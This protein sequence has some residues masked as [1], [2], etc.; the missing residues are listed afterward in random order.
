MNGVPNVINIIA[1]SSF[2]PSRSDGSLVERDSACLAVV[3]AN[4]TSP[5][6]M[7]QLITYAAAILIVLFIPGLTATGWVLFQKII[8][9]SKGASPL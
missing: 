6:V 3:I 7:M 4:C 8:R 5:K 2:I 1:A 9:A